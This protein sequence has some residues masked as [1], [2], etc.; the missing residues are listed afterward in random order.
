[1]SSYSLGSCSDVLFSNILQIT[2]AV[3]PVLVMC[4]SQLGIA[5]GHLDVRVTEHLRQIV[6]VPAVHHVPGG[7]GVTQV[8]EP[9]VPNLRPLGANPQTTLQSLPLTRDDLYHFQPPPP[10]KTL[11]STIADSSGCPELP[12]TPMSSALFADTLFTRLLLRTTFFHL[13]CGGRSPTMEQPTYCLEF[14]CHPS[15]SWFRCYQSPN[16]LRSHHPRLRAR[17]N[18]HH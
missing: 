17:R 3:V 1:M 15:E 13:Q 5:L 9:E 10:I 12:N 16:R 14:W 2:F 4:A 18:L 7:E 11:P 8:M 6:Q